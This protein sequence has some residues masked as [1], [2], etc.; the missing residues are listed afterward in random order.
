[1][2]LLIQTITDAMQSG[3]WNR[4]EPDKRRE[5][6]HRLLDLSHIRATMPP[7]P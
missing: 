7:L 5:L 2:I 4:W 3:I 6:L 1:M